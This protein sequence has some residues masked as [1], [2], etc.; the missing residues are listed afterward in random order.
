MKKNIWNRQDIL[1]ALTSSHILVDQFGTG[2]GVLSI[3]SLGRGCVVIHGKVKWFK[4][5]LP[6]APIY[7]STSEKLYSDL[8]YLIEN[9]DFLKDYAQKSIVYFKKY[10]SLESVGNYYKQVLTLS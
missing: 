10:H 4:E 8:I 6:E 3:E 1:N 2:Y 7:Y 5:N 9:K